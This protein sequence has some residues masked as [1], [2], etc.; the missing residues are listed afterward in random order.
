MKTF[1]IVFF[2]IY[3]TI[4]LIVGIKAYFFMNIQEIKEAFIKTL[5]TLDK[6]NYLHAI[7]ENTTLIILLIL[8][9]IL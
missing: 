2:I 5:N 6:R 1:I 3:F 8:L 7:I 4:K 9:G